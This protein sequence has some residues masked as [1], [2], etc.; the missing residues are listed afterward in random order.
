MG[1]GFV[2]YIIEFLNQVN[3]RSDKIGDCFVTLRR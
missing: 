3:H 1:L 2:R